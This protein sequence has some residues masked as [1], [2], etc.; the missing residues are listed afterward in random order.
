[1]ASGT[2]MTSITGR[3]D[4]HLPADAFG[5]L[6]QL[7]LPVVAGTAMAPPVVQAQFAAGSSPWLIT[8]GKV[9]F[10]ISFGYVRE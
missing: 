10:R 7:S 1:M 8:I 5:L 2:F 9:I 4:R 3:A 6:D